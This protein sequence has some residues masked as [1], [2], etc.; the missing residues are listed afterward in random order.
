[1]P[2]KVAVEPYQPR[3]AAMFT[4]ESAEIARALG[5]NVYRVHHVGSTAIPGIVA[6]PIID[7]LVEV[8][9]LLAVDGCSSAMSGLGYEVMGEF[10]IPGRRY[11]RKD[12]QAAVRTHHVHTFATGHPEIVQHLAFRDFLH[13]HPDWA[14]QYSDLKR[15]LVAAHP[16]DME[17]YIAGKESFI[18]EVNRRALA[19]RRSSTR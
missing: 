3:W 17:G 10:G 15:Q 18:Q 6:K 1:M 16:G 4:A 8:N 19:W 5:A 11:F 9:D 7:L 12:N 2:M 14:Q 13:A